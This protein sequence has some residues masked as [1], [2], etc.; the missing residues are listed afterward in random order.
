MKQTAVDFLLDELYKLSALSDHLDKN[1]FIKARTMIFEKSIEMQREQ[2]ENAFN[3]GM[4]S[5]WMGNNTTPNQYYNNTYK[6]K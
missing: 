5:E 3:D 2:I 6:T 4:Q 1:D